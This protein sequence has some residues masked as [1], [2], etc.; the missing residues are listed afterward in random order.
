MNMRWRPYGPQRIFYDNFPDFYAIKH[1]IVRQANPAGKLP[2]AGQIDL[3]RHK[4]PRYFS[5]FFLK[6][7]PPQYLTIPKLI[8]TTHLYY[9]YNT[10]LLTLT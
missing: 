10:F 9:W 4:S 6:S 1:L 2:F 5:Q 8:W 7:Y 3:F